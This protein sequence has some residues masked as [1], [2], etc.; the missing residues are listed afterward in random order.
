M[1]SQ[2]TKPS[3]VLQIQRNILQT[4]ADEHRTRDRNHKL[5]FVTLP[6]RFH[7]VDYSSLNVIIMPLNWSYVIVT[8]A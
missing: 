6:I 4:Y 7:T 2:G 5:P 3:C 8:S 1:V